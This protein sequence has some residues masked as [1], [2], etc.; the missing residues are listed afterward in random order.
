VRVRR[1]G[2][3]ARGAGDERGDA[4]AEYCVGG[5][6]T[7]IPGLVLARRWDQR[8]EAAQE[9]DR[10]EHELGLAGEPGPAQAVG[11]LA[12]RGQAQAAVRERR[13]RAVASEALEAVAILR[14]DGGVGV[15]REVVDLRGE[16]LGRWRRRHHRERQ[17]AH[18]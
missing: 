1:G 6:H 4:G 18:R 11:D 9:R 8:G 13:A 10:F 12:R 7:V 14:S 5:E 16:P 15:Q 3:R 2:G 17:R